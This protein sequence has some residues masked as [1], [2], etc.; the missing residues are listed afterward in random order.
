MKFVEVESKVKSTGHY[1]PGVISNGMLYISG[2]LPADPDTGK[3]IEGDIKAQTK[4]ALL[5]VERVLTAAG[6]SKNNVV[7]CRVYIP[8]VALWG[9]VNQ[10]Y[11]DFFMDHKPARVVVP[12]RNLFGDALVEIEASA[13]MNNND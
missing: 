3:T 1:T 8:D 13:E 7:Q 4:R 12:S 5:N 10:V 2:Q 11:S 6:L 9:D